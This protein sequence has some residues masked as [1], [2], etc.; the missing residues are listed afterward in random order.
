MSKV[1]EITVATL[2]ANID[3]TF[4]PQV[5]SQLRL[6]LIEKR[7]ARLTSAVQDLQEGRTIT[8]PVESF[9]GEDVTLRK[10]FSIVISPDEEEFTA[11]WFDAN[12]GATGENPVEAL[13]VLKQ[14]IAARF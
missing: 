11:T 14:F 2:F 12:I 10:P 9:E 5:D 1:W 13:G 3:T 7:V 6:Y 8:V 4:V